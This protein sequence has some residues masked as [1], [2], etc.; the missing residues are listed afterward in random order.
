MKGFI[1]VVVGVGTVLG[2][3]VFVNWFQEDRLTQGEPIKLEQPSQQPIDTLTVRIEQLQEKRS[4]LKA[5]LTKN[6]GLY[7]KRRSELLLS[8]V[9]KIPRVDSSRFDLLPNT[10]EEIVANKTRSLALNRESI[11]GM[12]ESRRRVL[13]TLEKD[14][15]IPLE[16]ISSR[17]TQ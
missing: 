15:G 3:G 4:A 6:N 11:D 1:G 10:L 13:E 9:Q 14:T 5:E 2:I 8:R 16:I 7:E 17:L 12:S